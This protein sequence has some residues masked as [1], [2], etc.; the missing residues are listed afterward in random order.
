MF[1]TDSIVE[2]KRKSR[3][4]VRFVGVFAGH[5][6]VV[7][8]DGVTQHGYAFDSSEPWCRFFE[9]SDFAFYVKSVTRPSIQLSTINDLEQGGLSF[10]PNGNG[11][12]LTPKIDFEGLAN[13]W[14]EIDLKLID[15]GNGTKGD[16][17]E[18]VNNIIAALGVHPTRFIT[19]KINYAPFCKLI[20]IWEYEPIGQQANLGFVRGLTS[21][22][23]GSG[24]LSYK[25][26]DFAKQI[27][28]PSPFGGEYAGGS[29]YGNNADLFDDIDRTII[30]RLE[31]KKALWNIQKP[32]LTS[33]NFGSSDYSSDETQEISLK[34]KPT[35]CEHY[36]FDRAQLKLS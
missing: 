6:S 35:N 34:F 23:Y 7:G 30:N 21:F 10:A 13:A 36:V 33:V 29:N 8:E 4:L 14:Q 20:K 19:S 28:S 2:P 16:L 27:P 22:G 1:F 3:F 9:Q 31:G 15:L 24:Q 17:E 5:L 26:L 12:V 25:D 18:N 32:F 11:F